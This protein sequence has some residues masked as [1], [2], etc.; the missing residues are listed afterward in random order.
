MTGTVTGSLILSK[1]LLVLSLA[2]IL[3]S[4]LLVM[5]A[6][7]AAAI[8][9]SSAPQKTVAG[10][11]A[12]WFPNSHPDVILGRVLKTY[13]MDGKGEPSKLKL[14]SVYLDRPM[15]NDITAQLAAEY[16]FK[17]YDNVADALTLGT[18]KLAVDGVVLCTEWADYPVSPIGA[19][20]HPHRQLFEQI[21]KVFK[22][23]D[24]VVPVFVDKHMNYD[25]EGSKWIYDTALEMKIPLMGGSSVP[26]A[27]RRP[28]VDVEH[29]AELKDIVGISYHTL[30]GYSF[31][32]LEMVQCLAEQRKGG[33]TGI[34]SAQCLVDDAVWQA[35]GKQYDPE[36]L[37]AAL[38]RLDKPVALDELQAKV[39]HPVLYVIE[40]N[41]GLRVNLFTLNGAVG[42]WAAA[43]RYG[44]DR[45]E[46]T[47][48]ALQEGPPFMHFAPLMKGIEEM[49][50]TGK[51]P[52]P[53]E[54]TLLTS[55]VLDALLVSKSENSRVVETPYLNVSYK[56]DWRWQEPPPPPETE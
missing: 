19:T 30:D 44:D 55:G 54:R 17:I 51:P 53:A 18:G 46:S 42:Q 3:V 43:W 41:D 34:K 38:G 25:W 48:F 26:L 6:G 23:S 29:D 16:G 9:E 35:A 7:R 1:P 36:L 13:T 33:E 49:I 22:D 27:W 20:M 14:V 15:K 2:V 45:V 24:R 31:H 10:I 47:L 11:L 37:A 40:C 56:T 52:W 8:P 4:A 12:S 21:V 28:P 32:G 50:L 39:P 5:Q